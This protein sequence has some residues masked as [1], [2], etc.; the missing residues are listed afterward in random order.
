VEHWD[1]TCDGD[2][3]L[4]DFLIILWCH[5]PYPLEAGLL[6]R[7]LGV[8]E[9]APSACGEEVAQLVLLNTGK[10]G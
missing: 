8:S 9:N 1:Q 7:P 3:F 6:V 5:N 4:L 2:D 10:P